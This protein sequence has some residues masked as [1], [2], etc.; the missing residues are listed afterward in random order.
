M[1]LTI[2]ICTIGTVKA[3]WHFSITSMSSNYNCGGDESIPAVLEMTIKEQIATQAASDT[4][5]SREECETFRS[6]ATVNYSNGGCYLKI[7]TSPCTGGNIGGD[8]IGGYGIGGSSQGNA[9]LHSSIAI[10]EPYF[11]PNEAQI[12]PNMGRDLEIKLEALN[13][14]FNDAIGGIKTG[15]QSFDDFFNRQIGQ[16]PITKDG[17]PY[18]FTSRREIEPENPIYVNNINDI[19][20][21]NLESENNYDFDDDAIMPNV[22]NTA[23]PSEI[24]WNEELGKNAEN[25]EKEQDKPIYVIIPD[26]PKLNDQL[27]PNANIENVQRYFDDSEPLADIFLRNPHKLEFYLETQ[28]EG[29]SGFNLKEIR[30]KRPNDRTEDEKQALADYEAYRVKE[31]EQMNKDIEKYIDNS[32]EKKEIDAAILALD[33][34]GDD[35]EGYI[36]QTNYKKL[37]LE[38]LAASNDPFSYNPITEIATAMNVCNATENG[39]SGTGVHVDLYYNDITDTY[40]ISCAGSD[41]AKD[42][43]YNNAANALGGEVPQYILAKAI[44]DAINRIPQV[45]RDKMNIEI[46]GH[47][48]GGG[49]ASVIGLTTGMET[50]TYNAA[51]VQESFLK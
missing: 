26:A 29:V 46:V 10:G 9:S 15:D 44:G 47:S 6:M 25:K 8:G 27:F 7:S 21:V 33:V 12:V 51:R 24:E 32:K 16:V 38:S 40:V 48:L 11:A 18:K 37:D 28:F 45:E 5:S 4:Y 14:G 49:M 13:K 17:E 50:K 42:W 31:M 1:L 34:Y 43:L 20:Q 19:E 41:D 2:L 23:S 39:F 22:E 36:H 35:A 30:S 3:Q